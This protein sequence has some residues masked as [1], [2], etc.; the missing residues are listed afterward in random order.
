MWLEEKIFAG[1][2]FRVSNLWVYIFLKIIPNLPSFLQ[3]IHLVVLVFH[4]LPLGA[5]TKISRLLRVVL[6]QEWLLVGARVTGDTVR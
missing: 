4:S 2:V 3:T 5:A 1:P 6:S